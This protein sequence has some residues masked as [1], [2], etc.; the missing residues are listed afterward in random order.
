MVCGSD[1]FLDLLIIPLCFRYM[2]LSVDEIHIHVQVI[3]D[4]VAA[5]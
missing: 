3:L 2:I 4:V 5:L 1:P